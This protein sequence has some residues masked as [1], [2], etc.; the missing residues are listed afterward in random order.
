[1][2][3]KNTFSDQDVLVLKEKY[4]KFKRVTPSEY[5]EDDYYVQVTRRKDGLLRNNVLKPS[6]Y[7]TVYKHKGVLMKIPYAYAVML[8]HKRLDVIESMAKIHNKAVTE[9]VHVS[10][11]TLKS[12]AAWITDPE[13]RMFKLLEE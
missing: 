7:P 3:R 13:G 1:M 9:K 8:I 12:F 6:V 11:R 5:P 10:A 4:I 2:A